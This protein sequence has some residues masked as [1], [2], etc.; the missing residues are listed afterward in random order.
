MK[1]WQYRPHA[2]GARIK[3]AIT[4][5][6]VICVTL[7]FSF[8]MVPNKVYRYESNNRYYHHDSLGFVRQG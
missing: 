5:T 8:V 4:S 1:F 3:R 6:S 7:I 2:L